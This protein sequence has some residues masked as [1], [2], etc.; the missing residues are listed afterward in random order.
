MYSP[1][2]WGDN[3]VGAKHLILALK[4]C[5]NPGATRGMY[6]EFLDNRLTAHSKVFEVL[7][8]RTKC[9]YSDEQ[10]SGVGFTAARGDSVTV[11]VNGKRA[12]TLTF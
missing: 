1:N 10:V 3:K 8:S 7:S 2:H 6:N 5:K 9:A 4:G 12:Y 11:V